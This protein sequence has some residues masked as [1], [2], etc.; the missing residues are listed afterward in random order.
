MSRQKK[1]T[2]KDKNRT[3]CGRFSSDSVGESWVST[4]SL[5]NHRTIIKND[6]TIILNRKIATR[7][8]Q[9]VFLKFNEIKTVPLTIYTFPM[10]KSEKSVLRHHD[11]EYIIIVYI[12]LRY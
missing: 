11:V 12:I 9:T 7:Y 1:N 10:M 8:Q 3:V 2:K 4:T 6:N 5:V